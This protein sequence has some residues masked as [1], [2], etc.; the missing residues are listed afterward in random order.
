M[1]NRCLSVALV[2]A[3]LLYMPSALSAATIDFEDFLLLSDV[4]AH[5]APDVIFTNATALTLGTY[6]DFDF[7]PVSGTNVAGNTNAAVP[8]RLDF[9]APLAF[10]SAFFTYTDPLTIEFFTK[11]NTSL[12]S[13][14]GGFNSN[15]TS[16]GN[17]PNELL[18]TSLA[19]SYLLITIANG[20]V[21]TM[22][23]VSYRLGVAPPAP[24]PGTLALIGF[25]I[26]LLVRRQRRAGRNVS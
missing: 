1:K 13:A 23:D 20:G 21:F 26:G 24:E 22:D 12:G 7:P 17:P 10:F 6:N 25:G 15:F 14:S 9:A 2:G 11:S 18:S 3:F 8:V 4:G 5:Y 16:S 19:A